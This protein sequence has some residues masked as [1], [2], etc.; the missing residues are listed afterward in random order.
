[1]YAL[2]H[3]SKQEIARS[4]LEVA[5]RFYLA[6]EELPAVVTLAGAAEEILGRIA[7]ARGFEPALKRTLRELLEGYERI[8]GEEASE[9]D[10]A[11]LRNHAKNV[12]KHGTEDVTLDLEHEAG[13]LLYRALENYR[14]CTGAP[15]PSEGAYLR[16]RVV[17]W[18]DKQSP[19]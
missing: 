4:Q 11:K 5:L 12:M 7:A 16:K 8:W 19:V 10:F 17:N 1:M 9:S 3:L 6:G 14:L 13:Q 15:H 2:E 18:R